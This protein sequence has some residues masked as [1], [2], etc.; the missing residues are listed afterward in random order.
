MQFYA[1]GAVGVFMSYRQSLLIHVLADEIK[2][3]CLLYRQEDDYEPVGMRR[4]ASEGA[5]NKLQVCIT[6]YINT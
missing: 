1:K 5:I 4:Y 3:I 2:L 6:G